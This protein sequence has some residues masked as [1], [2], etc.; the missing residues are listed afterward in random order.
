MSFVTEKLRRI[1][2]T[3]GILTHTSNWF[4]PRSLITEKNIKVNLKKEKLSEK[5]CSVS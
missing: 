5:I 3:T 2:S 4:I 1:Y